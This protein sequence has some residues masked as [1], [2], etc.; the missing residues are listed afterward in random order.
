MR[1]IHAALLSL[2][3]AACGQTAAPGAADAQ[4]AQAAGELSAADHTALLQALD[5]R[6]NAAGQVEN[7][8]GERVT[9]QIVRADL[10][11][12]VG[13]AHLVVIPGG[14]NI[15]TCYGDGPGALILMRREGAGF[16]QIYMNQ[17]GFFAV[18]PR[19]TNHAREIV[20]AGPGFQHPV[21]VW[22]GAEYAPA[23]RSVPDAQMSDATILP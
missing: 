22:N 6:A 8:C 12:A 5:M 19:E 3:L 4:P 2:A 1:T 14:P 7:A 21:F 10:G 13:E 17:G 9:P 15:A 16:R 18:L 23:R 11:Q 20:H